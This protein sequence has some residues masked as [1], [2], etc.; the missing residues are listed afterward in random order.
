MKRASIPTWRFSWKFIRYAPWPFLLNF[1]S[2]VVFQ[3]SQAVPGLI[4]RSIFNTLTGVKP[5]GE[6]TQAGG[7]EV[8]SLIALL[9]AVETARMA[10]YLGTGLG[11]VTFRYTVM[12]LL[13]RNLMDGILRRPG[14]KGLPVST[15][16]ALNRFGDDV[17][18]TADFPLWLP[19]VVGQIVFAVTALA[20]MAKIN[21]TITLFVCLPFVAV[22]VISRVAWARLLRYYRAG[23]LASDAVS[24]FLSELFGAVL[25][26]KVANAE[27]HM[28]AHFDALNENRRKAGLRISLF[29]KLIWDSIVANTTGLSIGITLLLA[30]RAMHNGTFTVG[31]F[32][33]FVS[34]VWQIAWFPNVMGSFIGDYQTQAVSIQRLD[35]LLQDVPAETLVETHPVYLRRG[36]PPALLFREK[37]ARDRLE[38]IEVSGLT[39][40]YPGSGKGIDDIHLRLKRGEFTVITGRIGSGK[41][42][43]LRTLLGLLPMESGKIDWNGEDVVDPAKVFIPPRC[44]YTG[45][46]PC[47]FSETLRDNILMG[48][49]AGPEDLARAAWQAVLEPD[50]AGMGQGFDTLVGPRGVRLSGGQVLRTAAARAFV[51][52]PELLVFDDLSSALDV[53]TE[54]LLWERLFKPRRD[55]SSAPT[56]LA[57][58]HRRPALRRADQIIV[59]VDGRVEAQGKLD[60]LLQT[61]EEMQRLWKGEIQGTRGV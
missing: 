32:A 42:T 2:S 41:T 13:R 19:E 14:S 47:L 9:V 11:N 43:L 49:P 6:L 18:E 51:R 34:Y 8:W 30:G 36:D 15:G 60:E 23:Q 39:Y 38:E 29:R 57:A 21:P 4:E 10:A 28:L 44:A 27:S 22:I 20:I 24:G 46:T 61:C 25:A 31:D 33:L 26:V 16:E 5:V 54:H 3:T 48:L 52:Q 17:G 45:Q 40:H 53:E 50:I 7:G 58:S 59:L 55:P 37:T 12:A 1:I 56:C 35:E